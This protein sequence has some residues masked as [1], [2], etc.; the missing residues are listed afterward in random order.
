[1]SGGRR[2]SLAQIDKLFEVRGSEDPR[3][4]ALNI[5]QG[6]EFTV[7]EKIYAFA[8]WESLCGDDALRWLEAEIRV[9][10]AM[11]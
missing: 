10:E 3:Q 5:I 1:V 9:Q 8:V 2:T 6:T 4:T 11:R 7:L